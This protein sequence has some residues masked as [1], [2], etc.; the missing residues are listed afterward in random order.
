MYCFSPAVL[1]DEALTQCLTCKRSTMI[2]DSTLTSLT[3]KGFPQLFLIS[4]W[5][6][7]SRKEVT[8]TK[9]KEKYRRRVTL[10]SFIFWK[11]HLLEELNSDAFYFKESFRLHFYPWPSK[12]KVMHI[13]QSSGNRGECA[14]HLCT[15]ISMRVTFSFRPK[16]LETPELVSN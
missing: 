6:R 15:S 14:R 10:L 3:V 8:K 1:Y 7:L 2:V 13:V 16:M 5:L 12:Q 9:S 11:L 4:T